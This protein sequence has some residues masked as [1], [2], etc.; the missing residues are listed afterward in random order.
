MKLPILPLVAAGFSLW[1]LSAQAE[2][3]ARFE[4]AF[5]NAS[6]GWL[7]SG[8]VA[9]PAGSGDTPDGH[10]SLPARG[11]STNAATNEVANNAANNV[12]GR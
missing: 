6:L 5:W 8:V 4:S 12:L 7:L 11:E 9:M 2:G 10:W 3:S 1:L